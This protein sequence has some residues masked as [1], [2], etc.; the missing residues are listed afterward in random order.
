[1]SPR[2][3][4][5][6]SRVG[7]P[8]SWASMMPLGVRFSRVFRPGAVLRYHEF[9]DGPLLGYSHGIFFGP[10]VEGSIGVLDWSAPARPRRI[11]RYPQRGH[12]SSGGAAD[13]ADDTWP[14]LAGDLLAMAD[15]VDGAGPVG[16]PV[17]RRVPRLSCGRRPGGPSGSAGSC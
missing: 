3:R 16:G 4:S 1:M 15:H 2:R 5:A 12:G 9:G 13:P 17:R 6:T 11:V 7:L 10:A 8:T 14:S